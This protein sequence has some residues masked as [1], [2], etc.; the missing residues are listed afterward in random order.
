ME[1]K[2]RKN[3]IEYEF[4]LNEKY[5]LDN[6]LYKIGSLF[7]S[8]DDAMINRRVGKKYRK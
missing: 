3:V 5:S 4:Y 8:I 7:L 1:E 6:G 2:T